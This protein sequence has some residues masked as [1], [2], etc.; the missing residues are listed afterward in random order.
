MKPLV[1]KLGG[2][3]AYHVEMKSWIGAIAQAAMPLVVV[4][5]GGPFADQVRNAQARMR[6]SDRAAHFMA[7]LA[8]EQMGFALAEMHPR[9][10]PARSLADMGSAL[11]AG[12]IPVWLPYELCRGAG[13]IPES[14]DMTS[15]SLGAWLAGRIGARSLLLIKQTDACADSVEHLAERGIVDALLPDMLGG[16]TDL[17]IAGPRSLQDAAPTLAAGR[18]PGTRIPQSRNL[19]KGA[20]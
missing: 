4:P 18:I 16:G 19:T 8:M 20:A 2:S 13:D 14:W 1:V 12:K 11:S 6:F 17:Y 5:G 7:I 9:L 10:V 15:D 3:T